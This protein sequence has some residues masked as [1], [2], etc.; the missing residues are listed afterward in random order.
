METYQIFVWDYF[1]ESGAP[2]RSLTM[3]VPRG[4]TCPALVRKVKLLVGWSGR[5]C[6]RT[7]TEDALFLEPFASALSAEIVPL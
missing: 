4:T 6:R 1:D 5:S 2:T 7:V 3:E